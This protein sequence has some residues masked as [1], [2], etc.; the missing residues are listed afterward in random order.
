MGE[1]RSTLEDPG[2]K[3]GVSMPNSPRGMAQ[4][5]VTELQRLTKVKESDLY[6]EGIAA[7]PKNEASINTLIRAEG[8]AQQCLDE[9]KNY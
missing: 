8:Y 3:P 6:Q 2:V 9:L 7:R 1:V 5:L 4:A